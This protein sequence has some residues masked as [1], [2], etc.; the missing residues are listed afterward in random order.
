MWMSEIVEQKLQRQMAE[1]LR[2]GHLKVIEGS[3]IEEGEYARPTSLWQRFCSLLARWRSSGSRS[4][5]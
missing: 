1:P 3:K 5:A 4:P 2:H